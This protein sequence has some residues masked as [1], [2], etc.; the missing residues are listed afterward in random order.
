MQLDGSGSK[1]A[2]GVSTCAPCT[3][4]GAAALAFGKASLGRF[5]ASEAVRRR[6]RLG[7]ASGDRSR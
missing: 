6:A 4:V 1:G 2:D 7:H 3:G 5:S